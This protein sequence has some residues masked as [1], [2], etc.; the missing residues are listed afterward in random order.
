MMALHTV[1][2][3]GVTSEGEVVVHDPVAHVELGPKWDVDHVAAD[4][5]WIK[6]PDEGK[7]VWRAGGEIY[8]LSWE[9][10]DQAWEEPSLC[11]WMTLTS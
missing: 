9:V 6:C 11:W 4:G 10:F 3:T 1:V 8:H 5:A 2:V 7:Q